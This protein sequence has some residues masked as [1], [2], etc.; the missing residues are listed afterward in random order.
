QAARQLARPSLQNSVRSGQHRGGLPIFIGVVADKQCTCPA[1]RL[2]WERYP[3]T[4]PFHC[5]ENEI[6][7]SLISSA[8]VGATPTPATIFREVIRLLD[9][10]SGVTKYVSEATNWSITS[11]SHYFPIPKGLCNSAQ[12]CE[13]RA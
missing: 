4:P 5:G 7:A 10:K 8:S 9:C 3:P 6:Q 12:G 1:S 2:M 13:E 11:T